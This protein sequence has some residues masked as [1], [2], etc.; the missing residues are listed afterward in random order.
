VKNAYFF[1]M[2][3]PGK[4]S[5]ASKYATW[6]KILLIEDDPA[7]AA[8]L[9]ETLTS[10]PERCNPQQQFMITRFKEPLK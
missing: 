4:A 8:L 3:S 9:L 1:L 5:L 7:I 10:Q 2:T 6:M